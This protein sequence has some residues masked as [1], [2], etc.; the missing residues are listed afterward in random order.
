MKNFFIFPLKT[1]YYF[2]LRLKN[3]IYVRIPENLVLYPIFVFPSAIR[4]FFKLKNLR[5]SN[6]KFI[7]R[8][9]I[10]PK[11]EIDHGI[12]KSSI[13]KNWLINSLDE[14]IMFLPRRLFWVIYEITKVENP[15]LSIFHS[16]IDQFIMDSNKFLGIKEF[17]PYILSE[18]I[19]NLTLYHRA[20]NNSWII[21]DLNH[22]RFL[23]SANIL[24]LKNLEFRGPFSTCNHLINNF[25]ALY[26]F[27]NS[28]TNSLE[29][30]FFPNFW[31]QI[32][33]KVFLPSKKIADGSIHYH[34]LIT[35]WLFEICICAFE[36]K[37]EHILSLVNPYL[38][39]NLEIIHKLSFK[40]NI[41]LMGDLSPDCPMEWLLPLANYSNEKYPYCSIGKGKYGWDRIWNLY[42][43]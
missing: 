26:L 16:Y 19:V 42:E 34:F 23:I 30:Y 29:K 14:E 27:F 40:D 7:N 18:C 43:A 1:L 28:N 8:R 21:N 10:F 2:F 36:S 17:P 5:S 3:S 6:Y 4:Y 9:S 32:R 12:I 24:L 38:Q 41:P 37:D 33:R 35:R 11:V 39:A 25:R 13:T 31:Y 15:N 20:K 22:E